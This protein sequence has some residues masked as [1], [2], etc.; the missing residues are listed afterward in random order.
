MK[1]QGLEER[2]RSTEGPV[3]APR[4]WLVRVGSA[5]A[6]RVG[7][8][9]I[10][11]DG[12]RW[13]VLGR[14]DPDAGPVPDAENRI[15]VNDPWM[16][17]AHAE[18][19]ATAEGWQLRDLG[20]SNGTVIQGQRRSSLNLVDG[21][22]FETGGTFWIFRHAPIRSE[23]PVVPGDGI[24]ASLSPAFLEM[25]ARLTK[26]ARTRVPVMLL[27][28]TGTGKEVL[29]RELHRLSNRPG[30]FVAVNTAAI[31]RTLVSSE[32]FGAEKGAHSTA[33]EAR[34]GQ[35][36]AADG[37][38]FVLDEIGDMPQEVQVSLL[39]VLQESE[40][41]P[42]G[43]ATPIKV[44]VRVVCATHQDLTALVRA[45]SFRADLYARIKGCSLEVPSLAAR[46]ED[47]GFLIARFLE[48]YDGV[49]LTFSIAAYRALLQY[50][51]P[52]NI[53]ELEKAIEGAVAL[54]ERRIELEHLP[55]EVVAHRSDDPRLKATVQAE[56]AETM[57]LAL[58][59]ELVRLMTVNHGNISKVARTMGRSRMQVHRWLKRLNVNPEQFRA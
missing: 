9:V 51:W 14:H 35:I 50:P 22:V 6:P 38:T 16:S 25:A 53:R 11:L 54:T 19:E 56:D 48:R 2:D 15:E 36:R 1:T 49:S 7:P 42:V 24:L 57:D 43:S 21:D 45:G 10:P 58:E 27:G 20:S 8:A 39:R 33:E 18:L 59:R 5:G 41:L 31:Q 28:K 26:V 47:I 44:D 12:R 32:L 23:L 3:P 29:A 4:T 34:V 37:G 13:I 30:P 46:R 52:Y 17:G 40:V 55:E